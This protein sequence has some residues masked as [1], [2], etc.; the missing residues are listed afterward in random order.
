MVSTINESTPPKRYGGTERV[1]AELSRGLIAKGHNLTL[2]ASGDS[3]VK[4]ELFYVTQQPL[5]LKNIRTRDSYIY[6]TENIANAIEIAN[7][8]NFDL[9]HIH[10]LFPALPIMRFLKVPFLITIHS[11]LDSKLL[12]KEFVDSLLVYK[13]NNFVSISNSQR[14]LPLNYLATVYN[15][16]D[17]KINK[18]KKKKYALWVGRFTDVKGA[19]EAIMVAKKCKLKIIL[20]GGLPGN[21]SKDITYFQKKIKPLF[22]RDVV[23]M[24]EV[25]EKEKKALMS[26]AMF[27]LNPIKWDEP[28]GLVM[29]ESMACGTPVISFA[30]GSP[31]EI[32]TDG[33]DGFLVHEKNNFKKFICK[34]YGIEGLIEAAKIIME[35][36]KNEYEKLCDNAQ[37]KV[38]EKFSIERMVSDYERVYKNLIKK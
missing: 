15:G 16:T 25:S 2:F 23:Y 4:T 38:R 9:V 6:S 21:D 8:N 20:A 34:K 7:K 29:T 3:K 33:I 22:S 17:C 18:P 24:G 10:E 26:E 37:A 32:I 30:N 19:W 35:M 14:K 31:E 28:F 13:D 1:V 36:D 11:T 5:F 27:F 12:T